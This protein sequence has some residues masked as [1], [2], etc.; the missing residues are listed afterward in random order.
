MAET[1]VLEIQVNDSQFL[2]FAEKLEKMRKNAEGKSGNGKPSESDFATKFQKSI[3]DTLTP[4]KQI[5]DVTHNIYSN[6][7][8]ATNL[9]LKWTGIASVIGLIGGGGGFFG[10]DRL[11]QSAAL[12]KKSASGSGVSI[13][14]QNAFRINQNR[15]L[16]NPDAFLSR[17]NELQNSFEKVKLQIILGHSTEGMSNV[18]IAEEAQLKA[19]QAYINAH[20][21]FD[22][23]RAKGFGE[24]YSNDEL[25]RLGNSSEEQIRKSNADTNRDISSVGASDA[26]AN[27]WQDFLNTLDRAGAKIN[28]VL[29]DG[30]SKLADPISHLVT[31]FGHL[32]EVFLKTPL[33]EHFVSFVAD[34]FGHLAD[35]IGKPEF[36]QNIKLF[37]EGIEKAAKAIFTFGQKVWHWLGLDDDGTRKYSD[38]QKE[39]IR[40]GLSSQGQG[41]DPKGENYN[42]ALDKNS[43]Q[44]NPKLAAQALN[45][46][47]NPNNSQNGTNAVASNPNGFSI[48]AA[49][50][51]VSFG[52]PTDAKQRA[53][54]ILARDGY[55]P[56]QIAGFLANIQQESSFNPRET[57]D[58]GLAF[59]L[60]QWHPDRQADF[61]VAFGHDIHDSTFDEQ[62][63]FM[64]YELQHK[65]AG[66]MARLKTAANA[67]DA[68]AIISQYYERPFDVEKEARN[69]GA[70][71]D[72]IA[73]DASVNVTIQ[74]NTGGNAIA[75]VNGLTHASLP[76]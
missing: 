71:A 56:N 58:G 55:T 9:L 40:L 43:S 37:A 26:T 46:A 28:T 8:K 57:G 61:K 7:H 5:S 10:I 48:N 36:E 31:N 13:G 1:S 27:K 39:L 20:G 66:A 47:V 76:Q 49:S 64:N 53:A 73:R 65:E 30:L 6:I 25:Q 22:V 19:R 3:K 24:L 16:N 38:E 74:N 17:I 14:E 35:Y 72:Q 32:V 42:P 29:I 68:G 62:I 11:A 41:K 67:Y 44:Y 33:F 18:Q 15:Y 60:G 12:Q 21:N 4:L 50:N 63:E 23:L 75:T 2:A 52:A 69:R 59:G 45:A 51:N 34:G 70:A 54:A